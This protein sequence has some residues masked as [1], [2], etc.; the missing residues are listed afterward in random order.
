MGINGYHKSMN[1]DNFLSKLLIVRKSTNVYSASRL[2][3]CCEIA[4]HE[5][6]TKTDEFFAS[7]LDVC[8]GRGVD[9]CAC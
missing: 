5:I 1:L 4:C 9:G 2:R 7:K 8:V 6:G 3:N